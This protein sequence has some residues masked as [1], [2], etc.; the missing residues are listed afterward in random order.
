MF[1][2]KLENV[3]GTNMIDWAK[4]IGITPA[5]LTRSGRCVLCPP[6]TLRPTT[7]RGYC[8]VILRC[9]CVISTTEAMIR[10]HTATM[11][12]STRPLRSPFITASISLLTAMGNWAMMPTKM[13]SEMPFPMPRSWICSPS[14][15]RNMVPVVIV[16]TVTKMNPAPGSM[17]AERPTSS[18][19]S[20]SQ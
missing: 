3:P 5:A 16:T 6:Y 9:P 10:T 14:H 11:K 13:I 2:K 7:R 18:R 15:I 4:M 17:T 19:M 12:I 1:G 8:T 20:W